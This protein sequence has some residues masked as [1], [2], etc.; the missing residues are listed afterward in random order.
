MST[1]I[2][3]ICAIMSTSMSEDLLS[4]LNNEQREAVTHVEGPLMIVAG[5]GTGKT[6]VVTH[7]IAWLIDQGHAKPEEILALTFTDKASGEMEERVDRLLP[8]GYVD[9][10]ISTFHSFAE[11]LL[12]QYGAELGLSRDFRLMTELDAWL[13]ARQNFDRFELDYYRPLGNPTKYIR[14]LLTHFSRAKDVGID[15]DA[16]ATFAE[17]KRADFDSAQADASVTSEMNRLQELA[18]AY[19]TYQHILLENDALDFGDLML[20]TLKLLRTRPAVRDQIRARYKFVLVDEF[21]D[22]NDAQYEIVKLLAEPRRNLTVVGDDDQ[23]IYK[24]RGA[25][26]ANILRFEHDFADAKRVVLTKNYRSAQE[27]LDRAHAFIQHNNP[28]RLEAAVE[29]Q[30]SKK[31]SAVNEST[32]QIEHIH[33]LTATEEVARVVERIVELKA[34]ADTDWSDFAILVRSNAAGMDFAVAL[35]R[36][37]IPYQFLALSGLYTKPAVLDL[38]AYL[39]VIDHPF[40]SPSF[41]RLLTSKIV[42][43]SER[44]ILELNQ[45]A[46]RKGKSLFEAC[47]QAGSISQIPA[48]DQQTI[49][50]ILEQLT[51]FQRSARTR[52][53]G[54]MFVIVA[55]QS[56]Y[57]EYLNT[58][59]EQKK[60]DSFSYLQQFYQRLKSFERRSDHPVLHHFLEEFAHERDAGEEGS[61][62]IDLEAGP[63]MV[64]IMTVHAAKGLEFKHV[65]VVNLIAQRFPTNQKN[66]AIPLPEG[67]GSSPANDKD[68]HLEEERRLFYVAMTRAKQG[69]YFTSAENYGGTRAR[70]LSRFLHE[71][72]YESPNIARETLELFDEEQG[73]PPAEDRTTFPIPKQFSFTQLAAFKTCPWQYKFAHVLKVPVM[74]KWTFSYGKTMHNTLQRFFTL[75]LERNG[76]QQS[77]LF[78]TIPASAEQEVPVS[79]KELEEA[80]HACW[81]D[82]WFIND[83]QREEYRKEGLDSLK[84]FYQKLDE[85]RPDP[86]A[87][88]QGFTMKFGDIVVKGRIDRIDRF[89]EGIEIIDYKT[90]S[91]KTELTKE[92]KEQ[93]LLYQLAARDVLGL[94]PKRLTY[95]YLSD[96]SQVSFLGTDDQL[97][98]LQESIVERVQTIRTSTFTPTPGFHCQ[99]CD[100]ADICEF[101]Q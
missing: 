27:I 20:Y 79:W 1:L 30:L 81:Q 14:S 46:Q 2:R 53:V 48:E 72:G 12:R 61:L 6:T 10:Q 39:R 74:G 82:D 49:H 24:F 40:D 51:E 99:F 28:N 44:S 62:S 26:L 86:L 101:R 7:R 21:Q 19:A 35:E 93:L 59:S 88:E 17:E 37:K 80:Y 29:R 76:S 85:L 89:E 55:K 83:R 34:Q 16:Y 47:E 71:L 73:Q 4:K 100:F 25:S 95:Y 77:S 65:F 60:L 41:Y 78:G 66:D 64:R 38:M 94:I 50:R 52:P 84:G 9:L 70:K 54:E 33:A 11:K 91:P 18:R 63:D 58:L 57:L 67:L 36:H 43:V 32:A 42:G 87:I 90:G 13:L 15:P 31:L 5:A 56:G 75:W 23:S 22:T 3:D 96:N 68:A 8:Y 92:G 69:L 97:L 98:D 45:W